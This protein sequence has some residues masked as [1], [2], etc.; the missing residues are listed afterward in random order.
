[1]R[2]ITQGGIAKTAGAFIIAL[3]LAVAVIACTG[4]AGAPGTPGTPGTAG[5]PGTPG[6]PQPIQP[7]QPVVPVPAGSIADMSL[8]VGWS[9]TVDVAGNFDELQEQPLTYSAK[10]D[11]ASIATATTD[12]SKVKVTAVAVGMAKVTVTAADPEGGTVDQ[13]FT[14]TVKE[15]MPPM[16]VG[17]LDELMLYVGDIETVD[18]MNAFT[19]ERLTYSANSDDT[20]IATATVAAGSSEV[21][22]TAVADG[23]I[24][25]T[26]TATDHG[27]VSASQSLRVTVM[28]AADKPPETPETPETPEDPDPEGSYADC[29][30]LKL[31]GET[32]ENMCELTL[33]ADYELE[34]EAP[35]L[36][37]V[38]QTKTNPNE[39]K[40]TALAKSTE[41]TTIS[42][43]DG[44]K[45]VDSFMVKVP[46]QRPV[47]NDAGTTQNQNRSPY[48]LM[49]QDLLDADTGTTMW[50]YKVVDV[51]DVDV[52]VGTFF[53]DNDND[54]PTY[55][56]HSRSLHV[57]V[58]NVTANMIQL[59]VLEHAG[60]FE[61]DLYAIDPDKD[62]SDP[63]TIRVSSSDPREWTYTVFQTDNGFD[64]PVMI[65]RR[66]GVTHKLKFEPLADGGIS[67]FGFVDDHPMVAGPFVTPAEAGI[68]LPLTPTANDKFL[69]ITRVRGGIG[70]IE[71][72]IEGGP[73]ALLVPFEVTTGG[74]AT[75]KFELFIADDDVP[76]AWGTAK[77]TTLQLDI[78]R[79]VPNDA[80]Y[81]RL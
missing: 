12:G 65:G 38:A 81:S 45:V 19:G 14:V 47:I 53:D 61:I 62:E 44:L 79:D 41:G 2:A 55:R 72:E 68:T 8:Q 26:V 30:M 46:N 69:Q 15:A 29:E 28:P 3:M 25:I 60:I 56:A 6:T 74:T 1:V 17:S 23:R 27:D 63:V 78:R 64:L 34:S 59:D 39:W 18:V 57:K 9:D 67:Q 36:V 11:K 21:M 49:R 31:D 75:I 70:P 77:A 40:V 22:V 7:I 76:P 54:T 42:V 51:G 35:S 5:T 32:G 24:F 13:M 71:G 58:R 16:A 52:K 73:A 80:N 50:Y 10:T 66:V 48:R 33:M 37:K 20:R 4:P 43:V